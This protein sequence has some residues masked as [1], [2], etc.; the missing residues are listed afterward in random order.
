MDGHPIPKNK[1]W[2]KNNY[3][4]TRYSIIKWL[5]KELPLLSGSVID[6]GAGN[7]D[8]PRQLI[9]KSKVKEYKTFDKK[10]YG[11][12]K[13]SVDFHGDIENLPQ[14][15]SNKWDS[16]LCIEV[17]ECVPNPFKAM[18]EMHRIL[19]PGGTLLLSCPFNYRAF[20]DGTWE[21]KKQNSKGVFDFWRP[22]KQGLELM[23]KMFSTVSVVG[24]GGSGAHDRFV[25]CMCAIK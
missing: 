23:A 5:E 3:S 18:S 17:I 19:K 25:H 11:N 4:E 13:N 24:F 20:G 16:A 22:T 21:D 12:V 7:W 8:V 1:T 10:Y 14:E 15:W 9:D 6:I 2:R